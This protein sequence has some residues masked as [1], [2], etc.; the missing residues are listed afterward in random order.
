M[1][2]PELDPGSADWARADAP[3]A[4]GRHTQN[5]RG[6]EETVVFPRTAEQFQQLHPAGRADHDADPGA[7]PGVECDRVQPYP[8]SAALPWDPN[9]G[10]DI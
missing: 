7:D 9:D 2:E 4:P 10:R 3:S 5:F 6:R 8:P 1:P